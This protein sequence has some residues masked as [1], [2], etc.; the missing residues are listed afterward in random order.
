MTIRI[1]VRPA[2]AVKKAC[3]HCENRRTL[4]RQQGITTWDPYYALCYRCYHR[5]VTHVRAEQ[6]SPVAAEAAADRLHRTLALGTDL[7]PAR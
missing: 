5:H 7:M 3:R 1:R 6:Q 4:F 2:P